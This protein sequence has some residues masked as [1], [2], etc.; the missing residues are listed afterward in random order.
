MSLATILSFCTNDARFLEKSLEEALQFSEE[1]VV[2]VASHFFD[3]T[4][5]NRA[6]LEKIYEAFPEVRFVEYPFLGEALPRWLQRG[7]L[8]ERFWHGVARYLGFL[9][10][11]QESLLFL[12]ADELVEAAAFLTWF[13]GGGFE[14]QEAVK[15]ANYW[16][17]REPI[18]RAKVFEDSVVLVRR[19][20]MDPRWLLH[21]EER[22][23]F[24]EA[25]KGSKK[26]KVLGEERKPMVH[27][28][29]WVRS[30]QEMLKKVRSWGHKGDRDWEAV[31]R[32]EFS[33]P[34][35]GKDFVHRY[36]FETV[37]APFGK[38]E[39]CFVRKGSS[40][41]RRFSEKELLRALCKNPFERLR[42]KF[43]GPFQ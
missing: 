21:E 7:V 39:P 26:R 2:S 30:E 9:E 16:Y 42:L 8:A 40:N 27:H 1:V 6:L 20:A 25:V 35:Q 28:F 22:S 3:G 29:S 36:D 18:Y 10:T 23:F 5:E 38:M 37:E 33:R 32:E 13:Q 15:L 19:G 43:T 17:F 14:G 4:P 11:Q 31:V 24:Y 41:V 12:D 34:F